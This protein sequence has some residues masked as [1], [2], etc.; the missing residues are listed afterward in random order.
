MILERVFQISALSLAAA[1]AFLLWSG[2]TDIGFVA[3]VAG[4]VAFFLSIRE[5]VKERNRKREIESAD[6]KSE[7][8]E[9]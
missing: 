5:Q 1:A 9:D 7:I 3:A 2:Q 8:L 6:A 4:S